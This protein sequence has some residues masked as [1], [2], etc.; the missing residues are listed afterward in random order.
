M[1]KQRILTAIVLVSFILWSILSF[2]TPMFSAVLG[3][4]VVIAA[5]EWSKLVGFKHVLLRL[6][7][8][9]VVAASIAA[10]GVA[11]KEYPQAGNVILTLAVIWWSVCGMI[12]VKNIT[13]FISSASRVLPGIIVGLV[14]L[15][16]PWYALAWIH[17]SEK[18][19]PLYVIFVIALIALADSGAYFSGRKWGSRKL[20]PQISPGKTWEGV[21]G[22]SVVVLIASLAAGYFLLGITQLYLG[23]FAVLCLV[24][25]VFTVL[26]DLFESM[27]KRQAG[28][29]DSGQIL[30]GHGGVLD[31]I[32]SIT[33]A[34]P[35]FVAGLLVL[36]QL[37]LH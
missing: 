8:V 16:P 34:A 3:L 21:W 20:A 4:F 9:I 27:M 5:W 14:V 10:L 22:A 25:F 7:F 23:L 31:R 11:G 12:I 28:V 35:V 15:V 30:P 17:G 29:K 13:V 1:L 37:N 19:G 36:E 26:G 32:D 18:F 2:S 24:T 33:A 6:F